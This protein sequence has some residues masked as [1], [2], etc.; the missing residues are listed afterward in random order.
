MRILYVINGFDP[1]GAEHGLLTLVENGF[2]AGHEL[3]IL[4]F[5]RGRGPLAARIGDAIGHSNVVLVSSEPTLTTRTCAAAALAL[6]R[7]CRTWRPEVV[8]LSLKQANVIGRLVAC[9]FPSTRCVSFEHISRYRARK[10]EWVYQYLLWALSIRVDEIWADCDETHHGTGRYF[11]PRTRQRHVV[12]LFTADASAPYKNDYRLHAPL[13][14]AAAGRLVDRK[15]FHLA[16]DAVA[17]LRARGVDV[18]LDI[19]GD[20]PE[21]NR[22][23]GAIDTQ[24]LGDCVR[25]VGYRQDWCREAV[26]HDIFVNLSDTEGFCI[27]VA[28]AMAA[29]LPVIATNVGGIREYGIDGRNSVIMPAPDVDALISHITTL[30]GDEALRRGLGRHA[31]QDMIEQYSPAALRARSRSVLANPLD[32]P[33]FT[34][35]QDSLDER[36]RRSFP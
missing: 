1:G 9:L 28:E 31:R 15:N 11:I 25:L 20:G 17:A 21:T 34:A 14:L 10:A 26:D 36:A 2:F 16:I 8:V 22:L 33:A 6:W 24:Q 23:Q 4:G 35:G 7:Q 12:P 18:R 32:G 3:K 13:R 19:F 29:A 27:V 30:A 5:C